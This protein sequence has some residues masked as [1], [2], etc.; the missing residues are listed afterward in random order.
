MEKFFLKKQLKIGVM[1]CTV[2]RVT[3]NIVLKRAGDG[4]VACDR[5]KESIDWERID[6]EE[7]DADSDLC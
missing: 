4:D 1:K 6:E 7:Y 5:K 2:Y 3:Y